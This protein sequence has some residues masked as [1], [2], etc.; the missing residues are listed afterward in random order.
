MTE[1]YQSVG[2]GSNAI[3][4]PHTFTASYGSYVNE[5]LSLDINQ[6]QTVNLVFRQW[7]IT[8]DVRSGEDGSQLSNVNIYCDYED[9]E[10]GGDTSNP[11]GPY[12]FPQ[13]EWECTFEKTLPEYYNKT[14]SFTTDSDKTIDV[15]LGLK[16]ELTNEEHDWLEKLYN[17]LYL[18]IEE[19]CEAKLA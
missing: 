3:Y 7:N 17:C 1:Y 14:V 8:F 13:A 15:V 10:Q 19:D 18:G 5:T 4:T 2:V 11:Y 16:G 12:L 9:F 6:S